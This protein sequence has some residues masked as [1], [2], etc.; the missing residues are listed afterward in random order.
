M[1]SRKGMKI[2]SG[3]LQAEFRGGLKGASQN[4]L[5]SRGPETIPRVIYSAERKLGHSRVQFPVTEA[6]HAT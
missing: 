3:I 2:K 4:C 5:Q 6:Y 1:T